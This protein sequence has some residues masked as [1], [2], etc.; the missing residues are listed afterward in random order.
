MKYGKIIEGNVRIE[1]GC[2]DDFS[3][4]IELTQGQY[5]SEKLQEFFK[6]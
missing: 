4:V 2:T 6:V 5:N 1:K 3:E